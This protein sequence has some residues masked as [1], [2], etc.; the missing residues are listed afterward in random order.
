M[1]AG[2]S[3]RVVWAAAA[4]ACGAWGAASFI[5]G[6]SAWV[7]DGRIL[8]LGLAALATLFAAAR[9]TGAPAARLAAWGLAGWLVLGVAGH[10]LLG[11]WPPIPLGHLA[12]AALGWL[13]GLTACA[14]WCARSP[15]PPAPA[16]RLGRLRRVGV[17]VA[18]LWVVYTL[19]YF[20]HTATGSHLERSAGRLELAGALAETDRL[21]PAWRWDDLVAARPPVPDDRNADVLL[22]RVIDST[23]GVPAWQLVD[24]VPGIRPDYPTN[25]RRPPK[26][27][28]RL[29][30][31]AARRGKA[32]DQ[33]L[34]LRD[35][36]ESWASI[37]LSP[38]VLDTKIAH[39]DRAKFGYGLLQVGLEL[40]L[41]DGDRDRAVVAV[42][43][44]AAL[45]AGLR[46]DPLIVVQMA[47][48]TIRRSA[49]AA[50]ER[51]L[52]RTTLDDGTLA[53]WSATLADEAGRDAL[54]DATRGDRAASDRMLAHLAGTPGGW[55]PLERLAHEVYTARLESDRAAALRWFNAVQRAARLPD[56]ARSEAIQAQ[57][58]AG[59]GLDPSEPRRG[60]TRIVTKGLRDF[61]AAYRRERLRLSATQVALACERHRL[62][63]GAWPES[64][65]SLVPAFLP[66]V[67]SGPTAGSPTLF[68]DDG[69]VRVE[70]PETPEAGF[71]VYPVGRRD[72]EPA[73][74]EG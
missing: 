70:V 23:D 68:P 73:G 63:R 62:A 61:A 30:A 43:A 11:E 38:N 54:E 50:M 45:G 7:P 22:Q 18:R 36:P 29:R 31:F 47:G 51:V 10:R 33:A 28:E 39:Y 66:A 12:G 69:G 25:R 37:A 57:I 67:P 1:T 58:N 5:A 19:A 64:V 59:M 21:D 74:D 71:S 34:A 55:W 40:A 46:G 42:D 3:G 27:L 56:P 49:S 60:H 16:T 32:I 41:E 17:A 65:E 24:E 13:A 35:R 26:V 9:L 52:G 2:A 53:R 8:G 48:S 44:M 6:P 72:L 15:A 4:V 14:A 20:A